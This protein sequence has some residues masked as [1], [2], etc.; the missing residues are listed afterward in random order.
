MFGA[1]LMFQSLFYWISLC[2]YWIESIDQIDAESFNPCF[3]GL[4][5]ATEHK[6]REIVLE[7]RFQSLFYWISLCN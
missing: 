4:A 6:L 2:N 7:D 5:S 3:I 1:R